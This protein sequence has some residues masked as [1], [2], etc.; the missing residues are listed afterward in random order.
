MDKDKIVVNG[1]TY[2]KEN[3]SGGC[4]CGT[5]IFI[6]AGFAVLSILS[7]IFSG[8]RSCA[9][10]TFG[11]GYVTTLQK[12]DEYAKIESSPLNK[13]IAKIPTDT[14]F[15]VKQVS[16]KNRLTWI[17]A[18]KLNKDDTVE[19]TYILIPKNIDIREKNNYVSFN[20]NSRTWNAYY[21]R[22]DEK[23]KRI[24]EKCKKEFLSSIADI[25]ISKGHGNV[26]RASIKSDEWILDSE[27]YFGLY[28]PQKDEFYYIKT[29]DQSHFLEEYK[30]YTKKYN[31]EKISYF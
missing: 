27:G 16:H 11:G 3:S 25:S 24:F 29:K 18:L 19:K 4:G 2:V 13:E 1:D 9:S 28:L 6:I 22:I 15:Y 23:N 12:L 26:E 17:T 5:I 14:V 30:K 8:I 20:E 21:S 31:K 10:D 7:M